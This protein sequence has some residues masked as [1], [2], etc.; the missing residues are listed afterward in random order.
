MTH[1]TVQRHGDFQSQMAI[2]VQLKQK[3]KKKNVAQTGMGRG[4]SVVALFSPC[5]H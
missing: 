5:Q 4:A 1:P 3:R 2:A